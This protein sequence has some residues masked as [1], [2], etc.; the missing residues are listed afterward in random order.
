MSGLRTMPRMTEAAVSGRSRV[1]MMCALVLAGEMIFSL[2]F[3][4]PRY[5]RPSFLEGLG[6][7]NT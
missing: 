7:S 3:H 2:P 5:F 4:L 6:L 1:V